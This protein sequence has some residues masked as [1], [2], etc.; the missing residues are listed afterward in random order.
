MLK[1]KIDELTPANDLLIKAKGRI[2]QLEERMK[3]L[4]KMAEDSLA[5][6]KED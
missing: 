5:M 3:D 4:E 1:D 2:S 6:R